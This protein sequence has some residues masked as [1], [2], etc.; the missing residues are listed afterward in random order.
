MKFGDLEINECTIF[1][2]CITIFMSILVITGSNESIE[3][4]KTKQIQTQQNIIIE[5]RGND[6]GTNN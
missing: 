6:N 4:E 3:K 1:I 5:E 2:I